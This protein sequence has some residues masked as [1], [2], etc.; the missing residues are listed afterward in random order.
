VQDTELFGSSI[1]KRLVVAADPGTLCVSN[2]RFEEPPP[3]PTL[4]ILSMVGMF[5]LLLVS[6]G[7]VLVR[8]RATSS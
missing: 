2:I 4:T 5:V 7:A 1:I 3:V 6:I 8:R